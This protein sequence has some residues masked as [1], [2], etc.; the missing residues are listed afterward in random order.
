MIRLL[1]LA[2]PAAF[3]TTPAR[4]H[5]GHFGELAGHDHWV[6][7]AG[8]AAIGAA[9]AAAWLKGRKARSEEE[10]SSDEDTADEQEQTA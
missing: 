2:V 1:T 7:G 4:S 10:A 5:T 3:A 9:A 6:M 8:L